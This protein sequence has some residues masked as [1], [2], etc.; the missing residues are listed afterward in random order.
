MR[1]F[2]S[3]MTSSLYDLSLLPGAAQAIQ[4]LVA[5]SWQRDTAWEQRGSQQPQQRAPRPQRGHS[6]KRRGVLKRST[7]RLIIIWN[8]L[9]HLDCSNCLKSLCHLYLTSVLHNN[10]QIKDFLKNFNHCV[11]KWLRAQGAAVEIRHINIIS[12]NKFLK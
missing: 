10:F 8:K 1:D 3:G 5:R 4:D 9:K 6:S 11:L 2:E 12:A 7:E